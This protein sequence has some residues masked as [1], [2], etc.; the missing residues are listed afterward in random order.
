MSTATNESIYSRITTRVIQALE[1]GV[2]PW[3]KEWISG[4]H[5]SAESS[6]PYRG[7]NQLVL[8]LTALEKGYRSPRWLTYLQ[9][10]KLGGSVRHGEKATQ[11]VWHD[12]RPRYGGVDP[13]DSQ[14]GPGDWVWVTRCYSLF[15][16][17]QTEGLDALHQKE[18]VLDFV[19]L[20]RCEQ[21]I[22]GTDVRIVHGGSQPLYDPR[23]DTV[24]IPHPTAFTSP[25]A[26]Y[27]TLFHEMTH[28]TGARHRLDRD[29]SGRFGNPAYAYE[30]LIAELGAC[31]LTGRAG[32]PHESKAASYLK[33]WLKL[34]GS[35]ARAIHSAAR[36][37]ADASEFIFPHAI[38]G[39]EVAADA[40]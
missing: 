4:E 8:E 10:K 32:I 34:L 22:A 15:N 37:A 16:L 11:V 6:R 21:I 2:V 26:Y 13:D 28:A 25:E 3:K 30:E 35:D 23:T 9:A 17:E 20:K 14:L 33:S 7:I 18:G 38:D 36:L 19:P 31:F 12:K 27:A 29:M 5:R 1:R 40:A 39:A 24:A